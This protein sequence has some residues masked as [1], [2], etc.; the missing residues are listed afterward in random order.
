VPVAMCTLLLLLL[1]L[2]L[3]SPAAVQGGSTAKSVLMFA[4]DDLRTQLSVCT[5]SH[6]TTQPICESLRDR[7]VHNPG[8]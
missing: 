7:V 6:T 5:S 8:I 4:V 1:L 2:L 3:G